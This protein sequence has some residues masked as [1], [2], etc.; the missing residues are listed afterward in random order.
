MISAREATTPLPGKKAITSQE[1][2]EAI[3]ERI[4]YA[5]EQGAR[6]IWI[7]QSDGY[8]PLGNDR[9]YQPPPNTLVE[10]CNALVE[11]EY[12]LEFD[13]WSGKPSIRISFRPEEIGRPVD[14]DRLFRPTELQHLFRTDKSLDC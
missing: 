6:C 14:M 3:S 7:G 2:L 9:R 1:L 5:R 11:K 10:V 12:Y 4:A 8:M 13:L